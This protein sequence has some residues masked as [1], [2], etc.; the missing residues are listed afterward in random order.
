MGEAKARRAAFEKQLSDMIAGFADEGMLITAGFVAYRRQVIPQNASDVQVDECFKAYLAGCQHLW[1]SMI[2][3]L[4]P[5]V[6]VTE[7]DERRM[8]NIF[9]EMEKISKYVAQFGYPTKGNA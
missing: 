6:E 5:G 8:E 3:F 7:K 2:D 4:E 9:E 1:A